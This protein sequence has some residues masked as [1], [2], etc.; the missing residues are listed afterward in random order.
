MRMVEAIPKPNTKAIKRNM[1]ILAL[2][3]AASASSPRKRP[4]QTAL[5]D[6]FSDWRIEEPSVG[7]AKASKVGAIAPCVRSRRPVPGA[8]G[9]AG[10]DESFAIPPPYRHSGESRNPRTSHLDGPSDGVPGPGFRRDDASPAAP[11]PPGTAPRPTP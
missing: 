8:R 11:A 1:T 10:F 6:P 5:I 9:C 4:T 7:K 2:D 3:V